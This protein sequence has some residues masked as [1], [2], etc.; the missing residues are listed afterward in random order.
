ML[1]QHVCKH[2]IEACALRRI[3]EG[4]AGRCEAVRG[5]WSKLASPSAAPSSGAGERGATITSE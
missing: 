4:A 5:G 2:S 3:D 1:D